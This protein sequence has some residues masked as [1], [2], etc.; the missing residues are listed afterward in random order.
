MQETESRYHPGWIPIPTS[1]WRVERVFPTS[2]RTVAYIRVPGAVVGREM[3]E[4]RSI[5][6][7]EPYD[8]ARRIA[9]SRFPD[10]AICVTGATMEQWRRW[11]RSHRRD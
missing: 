9:Q 8:V 2:F 4:A 1:Y 5:H 6:H 10:W 11:V 3:D 7:H